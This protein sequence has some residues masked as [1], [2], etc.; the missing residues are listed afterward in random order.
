M[1]LAHLL[2]LLKTQWKI[3]MVFESF[4][5]YQKNA[6]LICFNFFLRSKNQPKK[7]KKTIEINLV[8]EYIVFSIRQYVPS[9]KFTCYFKGGQGG[10][11]PFMN[12]RLKG[13]G[14]EFRG[15]S[16]RNV[17]SW[18]FCFLWGGCESSMLVF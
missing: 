2:I 14:E 13:E 18:F 15:V 3:L 12:C 6:F 16:T 9:R 11:R 8:L 17:S 7:Y 1:I 10:L 5:W 4:F